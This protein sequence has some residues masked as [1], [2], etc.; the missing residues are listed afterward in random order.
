MIFYFI[1]LISKVLPD[2]P[3]ENR[4]TGLFEWIDKNDDSAIDN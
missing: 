1:F 3:S 2:L 4:L